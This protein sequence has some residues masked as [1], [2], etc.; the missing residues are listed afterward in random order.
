MEHTHDASPRA[1]MP[2]EQRRLQLLDVA[3]S[4]FAER[5]YHAAAMDDIAEAAGVSKPVLYQHF[6]SK[7]EL[8]RALVDRACDQLV[9][10]VREAIASTENNRERV[11]RAIAA[12]YGFVHDEARSFR[13]VFESDL[14]G[15]AD[16]EKRIWRAY[17]DLA[18][19]V[20]RVIAE[21][22]ELPSDRA[23]LLG[24]ALIGGAQLSARYWASDLGRA[25]EL[26]EASD[27]VS[28]LAWRGI[29]SFPM[30][31]V[32]RAPSRPGDTPAR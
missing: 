10:L 14:T 31:N 19:A 25:V 17:T 8:Y 26:D 16:I 9:D 12:L 23:Y 3:A 4:V 22:T 21:D 13:F 15:D 30:A 7:H 24:M 28:T 6:P 20:G 18:E 29:R 11:E 5:G 27:L 1:R 2:R 32:E